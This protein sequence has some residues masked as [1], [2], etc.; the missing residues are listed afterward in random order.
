MAGKRRSRQW[1]R[2]HRADSYVRQAKQRGYRSRA[3]FKLIELDAVER[4]LRPGQLVLDLGA[5][6]GGWAQVAAERIQPGGRVVAVDLLAL[7]PLAH[8][9]AIQG[10]F[11]QSAVKCEIRRR[12]DGRE[13]DLV[14]S[15]MAPNLTGVKITDQAAAQAL[16]IEAIRFAAEIMSAQARLVLKVFHGS[17]LAGVIE[18]AR[19]HFASVR[20][21][22]PKASRSRSAETYLLASGRGGI[23]QG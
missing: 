18:H 4:L 14:I 6:P 22:K 10:D 7:A 12:I 20:T 13:V 3:A 5:A 19:K 2:D 1:L 15:D 16:A 21:V 23:L 11:R 9:E 17:E 8:V